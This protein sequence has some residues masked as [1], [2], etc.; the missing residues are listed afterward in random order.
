MKEFALVCIACVFSLSSIAQQSADES[1]R[2]E[3]NKQVLLRFQPGFTGTLSKWKTDSPTELGT[4][5][6]SESSF[7]V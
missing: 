6:I 5:L 7:R 1:A 3:A 4:F 2:L